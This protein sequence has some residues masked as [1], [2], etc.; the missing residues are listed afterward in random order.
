MDFSVMFLDS[1]DIPIRLQ[2]FIF[3]SLFATLTDT[4]D[5]FTQPFTDFKK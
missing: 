1:Q 3:A 2:H 5:V 4:A